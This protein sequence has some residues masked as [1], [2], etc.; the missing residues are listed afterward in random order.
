MITRIVLRGLLLLSRGL[1]ER[2]REFG[3]FLRTMSPER[4]KVEMDNLK[5]SIKKKATHS[6]R[7]RRRSDEG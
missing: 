3:A 5:A 1:R 4:Q 2:T 6:C 7:K